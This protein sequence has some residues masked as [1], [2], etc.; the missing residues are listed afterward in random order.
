MAFSAE[1]MTDDWFFW[2]QRSS[3]EVVPDI[4]NGMKIFSPVSGWMM[5]CVQRAWHRP[6]AVRS[7]QASVCVDV[8][9]TLTRASV[10]LPAWSSGLPTTTEAGGKIRR[11]IVLIVTGWEK[12]WS[13]TLT[14]ASTLAWWSE[15]PGGRVPCLKSSS[16]L[17]HSLSCFYVQG[18]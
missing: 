2:P 7:P 8:E 9:L 13:H 16:S 10:P 14:S 12:I 5:A 3:S 17:M 1:M 11:I 6:H 18:K 4:R 15:T